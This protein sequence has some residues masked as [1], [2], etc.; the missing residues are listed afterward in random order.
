VGLVYLEFGYIACNEVARDLGLLLRRDSETIVSRT[1]KEEE[2][3]N[4]GLLRIVKECTGYEEFHCAALVDEAFTHPSSFDANVASYQRLEW[5][6]DAVLCLAVREWL[7]K[8]FSDKGLNLG[9]LVTLEA[10]V[11][12]NQTLGFLSMKY[13]LQQFLDHG[14]PSLPKRIESYF[15]DIQNG[16]GVW[17]GDPPKPVA[18]LVESILGAVHSDGGFEAGRTAALNVLSSVFR[19]F[20][21]I[22][23]EQGAAVL[24]SMMKH[25]IKKLQEI[26]GNLLDVDT[27]SELVFSADSNFNGNIMH[28]DHWRK[29]TNDESTYVSCIKMLG[30]TIVAAADENPSISRNRVASIMIDALDANVELKKRMMTCQSSIERGISLSSQNSQNGEGDIS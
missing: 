25:P 24:R 7:I 4:E 17:G 9:D 29:S 22:L 1:K 11:V 16:S 23:E 30:D 12:C 21:N 19:V 2:T 26:S 6:G 27:S 18:D 13:G 28:K 3:K 14:D 5:V 20:V 8:Q 15:L 10:T